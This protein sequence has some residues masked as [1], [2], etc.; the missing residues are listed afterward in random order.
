MSTISQLS[1]SQNNDTILRDTTSTR[2]SPPIANVNAN[3]DKLNIPLI[4]DIVDFLQHD[5]NSSSI[6]LNEDHLRFNS[7]NE[8]VTGITAENT[9]IKKEV[10]MLT[11]QL[12]DSWDAIYHLERNLSQFQQYSRCENLEIIGLPEKFEDYLE[13]NVIKILH[14]IGCSYIEPWESWISQIEKDKK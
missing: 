4:P 8:K 3:K 6:Q 14:K 2:L 5:L 10:K 1:D 13:G 11:G 7:L 9:K 12:F